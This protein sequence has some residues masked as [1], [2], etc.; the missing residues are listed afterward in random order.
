MTQK[1]L[2][3]DESIIDITF[4]TAKHNFAFDKVFDPNHGQVR[5]GLLREGTD[6]TC[7]STSIREAF[8]DRSRKCT[9]AHRLPLVGTRLT[10]LPAFCQHRDVVDGYN[11][12]LLPRAC[13]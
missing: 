10:C 2:F 13:V 6:R 8:L 5:L 12:T 1:L 7:R 11:G 3:T 4:G 9:V